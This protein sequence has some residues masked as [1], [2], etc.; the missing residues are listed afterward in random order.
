MPERMALWDPASDD[1]WQR[2]VAAWNRRTG[3]AAQETQVD[4]RKKTARERLKKLGRPDEE[5]EDVQRRLREEGGPAPVEGGEKWGRPALTLATSVAPTLG[6]LAGAAPGAVAGAALG[7]L[8]GPLAPVTVPLGGVIGGLV[9]AFGGGWGGS[10]LQQMALENQ[11]IDQEVAD[12]L[13]GFRQEHPYASLGLE[14]APQAAALRPG[15]GTLSLANLLLGGGLGGGGEVWAAKQAG[16]PVDPLRV[17]MAAG[18]GALLSQ[19]Y[20]PLG[21]RAFPGQRHAG[22]PEA[23]AGDQP[24]PATPGRMDLGL[25][26][27]DLADLEPRQI[28]LSR[29]TRELPP[30]REPAGLLGAAPG[31]TPLAGEKGVLLGPEELLRQQHERVFR[32]VMDQMTREGLPPGP[33]HG[34][35]QLPAAPDAPIPLEGGVMET[36]ASLRRQQQDRVAQEAI[37]A[38]TRPGLPPGPSEGRLALPGITETQWMPN[39]EIPLGDE[40]RGGVMQTG[41]HPEGLPKHP[42]LYQP[43][44]MVAALER[45]AA[46]APAPERGPVEAPLARRRI[47]WDLSDETV[48]REASHGRSVVEVPVADV[49]RLAKED[50]ERPGR[51][52]QKVGG[53]DKLKRADAFLRHRMEM[54]GPVHTPELEVRGGKLVIGDGYHRTQ[55]AADLGWK[56]IPVRVEQG[57]LPKLKRL[58]LRYRDAR[59]AVHGGEAQARRPRPPAAPGPGEAGRGRGLA[60]AEGRDPQARDSGVGGVPPAGLGAEPAGPQLGRPAAAAPAAPEQDPSTL[61]L[62]EL[63]GSLLPKHDP[64]KLGSGLGSAS[65]D[66]SPR[67]KAMRAELLRRGIRTADEAATALRRENPTMSEVAAARAGRMLFAEQGRSASGFDVAGAVRAEGGSP[68]EAKRQIDLANATEGR[69]LRDTPVAQVARAAAGGRATS[70]P[71]GPLTP[72]PGASAPQG[73]AAAA[74]QAFAGRVYPKW[75]RRLPTSLVTPMPV[76]VARTEPGL[77]MVNRVRTMED[78]VRRVGMTFLKG[79]NPAGTRLGFDPN[80]PGLEQVYE[81]VP[82]EYRNRLFLAAHEGDQAPPGMRLEDLVTPAE[83]QRILADPGVRKA[84]Q[85][86][87]AITDEEARLT[88]APRTRPNYVRHFFDRESLDKG[89]RQR[90]AEL[91]KTPASPDRDKRISWMKDQLAELKDNPDRYIM[92]ERLKVPAEARYSFH[93]A[94]SENLPYYL[95]DLRQWIEMYA[96]ASA[97]KIAYDRH[98]PDLLALS[99]QLKP[100]KVVKESGTGRSKKTSQAYSVLTDQYLKNALGYTDS[101]TATEAHIGH[102]FE[103]DLRLMN[104]EDAERFQRTLQG[105]SFKL[106]IDANPQFVLNRL[107]SFSSGVPLLGERYWAA[108][109]AKVTKDFARRVARTQGDPLVTR[110][111][112]ELGLGLLDT[113]AFQDEGGFS[114]LGRRFWHGAW[115]SRTELGNHLDVATGRYLQFSDLAK[116]AA[117]EARTT[118]DVD[119]LAGRVLARSQGKGQLFIQDRY[120]PPDQQAR[121]AATAVLD[122]TVHETALQEAEKAYKT[123]IFHYGRSER[124]LAQDQN[125]ML[126]LALQFQSFLPRQVNYF[127]SRLTTKGK[128][129]FLLYPAAIGGA[130]AVP[131]VALLA[132]A[133]PAVDRFINDAEDGKHGPYVRFL[134][135]ANLARAA[136][137]AVPSMAHPTG[138]YLPTFGPEYG[139][140][141]TGIGKLAQGAASL[142]GPAASTAAQATIPGVE[143][144][145]YAG[146]GAAKEQLARGFGGAIPIAKDVRYAATEPGLTTPQ[147]YAGLAGFR[148]EDREKQYGR[149]DASTDLQEDER[150]R[151]LYLGQH[152]LQNSADFNLFLDKLGMTAGETDAF[153]AAKGKPPDARAFEG[154]RLNEANLDDAHDVYLGALARAKEGDPEAEAFGRVVSGLYIEKLRDAKQRTKDP[155]ARGRIHGRLLETLAAAKERGYSVGQPH[156]PVRPLQ[157]TGAH[158]WLDANLRRQPAGL[159][160]EELKRRVIDS[161]KKLKL[162]D[163]NEVFYTLSAHERAG[164]IGAYQ[165][166]LQER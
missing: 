149:R 31:I 122:G 20:G 136:G 116:I 94:R 148:P 70:P 161:A 120:Y 56:T 162:S 75:T 21:R 7:A 28:D 141:Q 32:E 123:S 117:S 127:W 146:A 45:E 119:Q 124:P 129:K 14:L 97:R 42:T 105:I 140:A 53:T 50:I 90:I 47:P 115:F 68:R 166:R 46:H 52:R 10:K 63:L 77:E 113:R 1:D 137:A 24:P 164:G 27:E 96:H 153:V 6:G 155:A 69:D 99:E 101:S 36:P 2:R 60:G 111:R 85:M 103:D 30:M 82:P 83:A 51:A 44:G 138:K 132:S 163:R 107:Q 55:A 150:I 152:L 72:P 34:M 118:R 79:G 110:I 25:S 81:T 80:M 125:S 74:A 39:G 54:G 144:A 134:F 142:L 95:T 114:G 62:T 156:T 23:P 88:Q 37:A 15:K 108:G 18:G 65:W 104:A 133:V 19:P 131:F 59:G 4:L 61:P 91:Q 48:L 73:P 43:E 145:V 66:Q 130:K 26:P 86:L 126:R 102:L 13:H 159:D 98:G 3:I 112:E 33:R 84:S 64:T 78:D 109:K 87:R 128:V 158:R 11:G 139:R 38:L 22:S 160:D 89:L 143:A 135:R 58:G 9:G 147:R 49:L 35:R 76:D 16:E 157:R 151:R 93:K 106:F 67:A 5:A 154:V 92:S 12:E 8:G 165:R 17:A 57:D 41:L 121:R 29:Q 71:T 40:G 100:G